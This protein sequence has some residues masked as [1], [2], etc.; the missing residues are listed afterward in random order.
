MHMHAMCI[1]VFRPCMYPYTCLG[2]HESTA[3]QQTYSKGSHAWHCVVHTTPYSGIMP[4]QH[5]SRYKAI[6]WHSFTPNLGVMHRAARA[7]HSMVQHTKPLVGIPLRQIQVSCTEQ[8]AQFTA[9]FKVQ[10][11][12]LV[13]MLG[14]CH[15]SSAV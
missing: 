3:V 12:L 6:G 11:N 9:W 15:A 7:V 1:A 13:G 2:I 5:G 10:S 8:H 4:K 14:V